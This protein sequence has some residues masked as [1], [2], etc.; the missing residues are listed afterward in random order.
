MPLFHSAHK[1]PEDWD[2]PQ[3]ANVI[4]NALDL[5]AVV[6]K[7]ATINTWQLEGTITLSPAQYS[8]ITVRSWRG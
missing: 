7:L 1:L 6:N 5:K 2:E 3:I 8:V 4:A